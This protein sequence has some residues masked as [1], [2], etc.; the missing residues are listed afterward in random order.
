MKTIEDLKKIIPEILRIISTRKHNIGISYPEL[1]EDGCG[2]TSEYGSNSISYDEDGW[3]IEIGYKC[4]GY[5]D[6]ATGE[7]KSVFGE[8]TE[9]FVSHYDEDTDEET[10]FSEEDCYDLGVAIDRALENL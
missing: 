9:I 4:S 3:Q 7:Y 2:F 8:V 5:L 6:E 1:N 10:E